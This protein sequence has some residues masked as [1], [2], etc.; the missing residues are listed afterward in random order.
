MTKSQ[1]K[2]ELRRSAMEDLCPF[3]EVEARAHRY[4]RDHLTPHEDWLFY[5]EMDDEDRR[6]LFLLYSYV[7]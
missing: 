1:I 4:L 7:L 2:A 3:W 5:D 6:S